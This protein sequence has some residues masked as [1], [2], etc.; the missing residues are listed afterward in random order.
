MSKKEE[1]CEIIEAKMIKYAEN[2][3]FTEN[4]YP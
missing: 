3:I 2:C 4:I 1:K